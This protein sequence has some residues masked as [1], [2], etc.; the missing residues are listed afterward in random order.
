[1]A[2][3]FI[4]KEGFTKLSWEDYR[5]EAKKIWDNIPRGESKKA[6]VEEAL[7]IGRWPDKD[8]NMVLWEL[9]SNKSKDGFQR[10]KKTTRA[11]NQKQTRIN[12]AENEKFT[13]I[14][15]QEAAAEWKKKN[16]TDWNN[17]D[18]PTGKK[19][20]KGTEDYNKYFRRYEHR[21]KVAD[22]F[23]KGDTGLD[24]MSGD[25]ENLTWTTKAQWDAKDAGEMKHGKDFIFDV[26]PYDGDV[27]YTPRK[28][29]N[30]HDAKFTKYDIGKQLAKE[31]PN[32]K[33]TKVVDKVNGNGL[34]GNGLNGN[35]SNGLVKNGKGFK[36]G[37]V[38]KPNKAPGVLTAA[39]AVINNKAVRK[40]VRWVPVV[41]AGMVLLNA[42]AQAEE[43]IA[44]P[45]WQ[46]KTQAGIAGFDAALEGVELATGGVAG[47]VTTPLQIGLMFADQMIHQ[48][49]D[50]FQRSETDW[51]ARRAARRGQR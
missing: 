36:N 28:S 47:L 11:K 48:T 4:D 27:V 21:I 33:V 1:M 41:G 44:N 31:A 13:D 35:G 30:L 51:D 23:W 8:G 9:N 39:G 17:R 50:S 15:S 46:N 10:K 37:K 19:L 38:L 2:N 49:E 34:N 12:R 22:P 25:P 6:V 43:A 24:Y 26:D 5:K 42:K 7:G 16:I 40:A 18:N 14:T 45:T 29:G 32:Y 3:Q 20:V